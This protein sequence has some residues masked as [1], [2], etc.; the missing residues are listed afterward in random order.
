MA[1]AAVGTA[2]SFFI[3]FFTAQAYDRWWE[4][5][6]IW[7]QFVNYSR[8][9]GRMVLTLFP[10]AQPESGVSPIQESL[11]RRHIAYLYAVKARLRDEQQQECLALLGEGD[12]NSAE[13]ARHLGNVLLTLQGKEL[14]AAEREGLIDVIRLAQFNEMLTS[15][16]NSMGAAERIKTTVF[17][18]FYPAMI[19]ASIWTYIIVFALSLSEII[20]Y[21]AMPY[22]FVVGVIFHLVY[23]AGQL[24]LDPF[25][26][27]PNDIP[28]SNIVRTIEINLL[29][30]LGGIELPPA[31]EPV[32]GRYLM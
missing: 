20:G 18:P 32:D 28:M 16:S 6:K 8:S 7:G 29:E 31:V 13:K 9:F 4:A 10:G 22:V 1:V 30:Q 3:G 19:R 12:K 23:D 26:G 21:W 25:E 17:P 24:M 5:R 2:V 14:D 15:F 11:I 27:R